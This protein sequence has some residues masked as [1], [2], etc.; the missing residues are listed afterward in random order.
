[1]QIRFLAAVLALAAAGAVAAEQL[2]PF[3]AER[4]WQ[5]QRIGPPTV[6]PDGKSAVAAVTRYDMKENKGLSDL[7]LWSTDGKAGRALTTHQASDSSPLY[8]PDGQSLAFIS[9]REGDTAP[10]LYLMPLGGGEPQRLTNVPTGVAQPMWFPDGKR[11]A[12]LSRVWP[13]LATMTQ[14]GERQ[15]QRAEAKTSAQIWDSRADLLLGHL[16]RRPAAARVQRRRRGWRAGQPDRRH[17]P[18][19]AAQRGAARIAAVRHLA[20]RRGTRVRRRL[21]PGHQPHQPRRLHGRDR[22][23][24]RREPHAG[25]RGQRRRA[26][27]QPGR[28]LA[29]LRAADARAAST[30]TC[31]A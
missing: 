6:S 11:I 8:S 28:P 23:Q 25:Q 17:R 7:W 12:F 30:A 18:R 24:G 2:A 5:I 16:A 21:R 1:M 10:Q 9:Q 31:A 4:S 20:G 29:R 19:V 22:R 27:L 26:A 3:S 13:D 14:Q 15:K